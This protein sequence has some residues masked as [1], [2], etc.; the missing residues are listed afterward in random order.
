LHLPLPTSQIL[1]REKDRHE[2]KGTYLL[3]VCRS[4]SYHVNIHNIQTGIK[5]K[6]TYVIKEGRGERERVA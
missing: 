1:K 3:G 4:C 6:E 2:V 5:E